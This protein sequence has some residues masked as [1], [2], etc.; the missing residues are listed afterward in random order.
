[1]AKFESRTA[2]AHGKLKAAYSYSPGDFHEVSALVA[3]T[4]GMDIGKLHD[5]LCFMEDRFARVGFI[6]SLLVDSQ[7]RGQGYG[8]ELINEYLRLV[9]SKTEVDFLLA[10]INVPQR[11]GFNLI[12]FYE[13]HGFKAVFCS[14]EEVL[15][16]N[17]GHSEEMKQ[18]FKAAITLDLVL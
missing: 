11:S 4:S 2:R 12:N 5:I 8:S 7:S 16:V 14:D 9:S 15:M 13:R 1:M 17:K 6:G 18:F 10:R 3:D